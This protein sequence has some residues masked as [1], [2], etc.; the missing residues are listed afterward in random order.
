[1]ANIHNSRLLEMTKE[2]TVAAVAGTDYTPGGAEGEKVA[3]FM[4]HIYDKLRD[5]ASVGDI[6]DD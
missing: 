4:Q 6:H 1:M 3:E 2:I 5:L